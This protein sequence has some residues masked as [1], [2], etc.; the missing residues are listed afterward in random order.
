MIGKITKG[1]EADVM[2]DRV[3]RSLGELSRSSARCQAGAHQAVTGDGNISRSSSLP[4]ALRSGLLPIV[5]C[6]L[7]LAGALAQAAEPNN[8]LLDFTAT[9]CGP[10]QQMSAIVSRLE[11]QGFPI[12]KVDID[13][14]EALA[15]Q[16]NVRSIP[17]FVL[18]A[19]G[20]EVNRI[21]GATDEKEL[22]RLLM[23][24]PRQN[25]D[26]ALIGKSAGGSALTIPVSKSVAA[27]SDER[28]T[29]PRIPPLFPKTQNQ[30]LRLTP[31]D[32]QDLTVRGQDPDDD[33]NLDGFTRDPLAASVRIRVK[34][35]SRVNFGSGTI[36]D[37]QRGRAV[38]LTCGHIFRKLGKDAIVEVDLFT[39][40]NA[41]PQTIVGKIL[42]FDLEA[43]VGLLT[44]PCQQRLPTIKL[45]ATRGSLAVKERV[46][47]IGCG[48]GDRP[49]REDLTLT[50]INKYD[51]PDN[52][53]CSGVP[54]QGRSG[55]GLFHGAEQIG[56]CIAAD[57]QGKRGIYTGLK[58]IVKLLGKASLA[59]L[60][61][62]A[63]AAEAA[64]AD[65]RLQSTSG[66]LGGAAGL[67]VDPS[68]SSSDD[69][70]R[71]LEAAAR[72]GDGSSSESTGGSQDYL[73]AEVVC[74]VRPRKAGAMSRV[75]I[76]NQA[77]SRFVDDLL[78]ESNGGTRPD[79]TTAAVTPARKPGAKP[80]M[81]KSTIQSA[82]T[83]LQ[84]A[85]VQ[86]REARDASRPI[87]TSLELQRYRRNR[88]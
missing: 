71:I 6:W 60:V 21:T 46:C 42:Q 50:A 17:C 64:I 15:R 12:R 61:P 47:S 5:G 72:A 59:H 7:A 32:E 66:S 44:I 82:R 23:M 70:A 74:I 57:P 33:A 63:S 34:D 27:T 16:Y 11:R 4:S 58:P 86:A 69:V 81:P 30:N 52:I 48:G 9:W 3:S 38:I 2:Q 75:V 25:I 22:R 45:G 65:V 13:E 85:I 14:Q 39:G 36:I 26:E 87:E 55:G 83:D 56:V 10:C 54:Q 43:D 84:N 18:I 79:S 76:V 19:N 73:G 29:F 35:G 77:S 78:H 40:G 37:S 67:G 88:D 53:E 62:S 20:R 68:I 24:L 41:K 49:T 31:T 1:T 28:K 51:G 8:V 80:S